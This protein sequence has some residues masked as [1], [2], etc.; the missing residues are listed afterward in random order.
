MII[1]EKQLQALYLILIDS[2]SKLEID[3]QFKLSR[4]DRNELL[5]T[6]LDQQNDVYRTVE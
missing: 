4:D 5:H 6:I 2:L 3:G 1:T